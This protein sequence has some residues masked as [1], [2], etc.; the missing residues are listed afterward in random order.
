M[1]SRS[2]AQWKVTIGALLAATACPAVHAET[3]AGI[4]VDITSRLFL[5]NPVAT[6]NFVLRPSR[7]RD[8]DVIGGTT[9]R[10]PISPPPAPSGLSS[11]AWAALFLALGLAGLMLWIGGSLPCMVIGHRRSG[12]KVRFSEAEQRWV[13]NCKRCGARLVRN[14]RGGWKAAAVLPDIAEPR[15]LLVAELAND[16][17]PF[18]PP[19]DEPIRDDPPAIVERLVPRSI[20][21]PPAARVELDQRKAQS[22]IHKLLG[23]VLEGNVTTP[24]ARGTLFF[25]VDELRASRGRDEQTR[26]AEKISIRIQQLESALRRGDEQQ[27]SSARHELEALADEWASGGL[28]TES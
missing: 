9:R 22:I 16:V 24:G 5:A 19:V 4:A 1:A 13:S 7:T 3:G 28:C 15:L 10:W 2:S 18:R 21:A 20:E 14:R 12:K 17:R 25:V 8:A 26:R 27:A 6:T 23:D 11:A